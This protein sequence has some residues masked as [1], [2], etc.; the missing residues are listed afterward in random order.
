MTTEGAIPI[1]HPL[2]TG[3]GGGP[4]DWRGERETDV[5]VCGA[6]LNA[7]NPGPLCSACTRRNYL[8]EIPGGRTMP[9]HEPMI[10]AAL[11]EKD[12][13]TLRELAEA[14]GIERSTVD[15]VVKGGLRGKVQKTKE[16]V[17][18]PRAVFVY[19]LVKDEQ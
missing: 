7:Y 9:Q 4:K 5:C 13:L 17:M 3:Q 8:P 2:S 18:V 6:Y 14:T 10:L 16:T 19:R 1:G 11:K 15:S 12:G